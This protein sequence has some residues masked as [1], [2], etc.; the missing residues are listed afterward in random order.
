MI[1][2]ARVVSTTQSI[3][4]VESMRPMLILY[5]IGQ[6]VVDS[7]L[8]DVRLEWSLAVLCAE[9]PAAPKT[10]SLRLVCRL[11]EREDCNRGYR[12]GQISDAKESILL[13]LHHV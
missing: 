6:E 2:N 11:Y 3:H 13:G 8:R 1:I 12:F 10:L 5:R 7:D 9:Y 4:P